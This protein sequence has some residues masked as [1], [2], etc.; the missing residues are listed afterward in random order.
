[1]ARRKPIGGR[2]SAAVERHSVGHLQPP[3]HQAADYRFRQ[4]L[5]AVQVIALIAVV[6]VGLSLLSQLGVFGR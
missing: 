5:R 3:V 2:G 1:M 4:A 6:C